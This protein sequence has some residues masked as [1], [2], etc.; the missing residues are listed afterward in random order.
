[1]G[2]DGRTGLV[3][4]LRVNEMGWETNRKQKVRFRG[5][6]SIVWYGV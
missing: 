1:M 6:N 5:M 4:N 3:K 2:V